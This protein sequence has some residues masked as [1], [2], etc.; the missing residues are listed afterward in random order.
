MRDA[1]KYSEKDGEYADRIAKA[2]FVTLYAEW[3]ERFR[4]MIAT[5]CGVA[6]K[7]IKSDLMGDVRLVRHWIVHNKS[8]VNKKRHDLK[9][10]PWQFDAGELK[11]TADRFAAFMVLVNQTEFA[12]G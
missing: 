6:A 8:V 9:V 1:V 12:I 2:M 7:Q 3:D 11:I 10:L 5:E 4:K